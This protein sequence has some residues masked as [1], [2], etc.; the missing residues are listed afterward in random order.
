[1][2]AFIKILLTGL[3]FF[4]YTSLL[5]LLSYTLPISPLSNFVVIF[6]VLVIVIPLSIWSALQLIQTIKRF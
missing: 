5:R 1:M 4:V 3:F 2:K 6:I